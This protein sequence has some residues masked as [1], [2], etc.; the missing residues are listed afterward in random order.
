ML[1]VYVA[2]FQANLGHMDTASEQWKMIG[3]NLALTQ[4][5]LFQL[6]IDLIFIG[7]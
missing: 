4:V 3:G 5:S 6:N 1:C 7:D 2:L